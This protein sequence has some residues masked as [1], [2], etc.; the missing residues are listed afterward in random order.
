VIYG[1]EQAVAGPGNRFDIP[2]HP[3]LDLCTE[4]QLVGS[5]DADAAEQP[6][7]REPRPVERE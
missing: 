7:Q 2:F 4:P 3:S 6:S 5:D 1:G